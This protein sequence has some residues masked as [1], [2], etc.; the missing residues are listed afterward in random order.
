MH[1]RLRECTVLFT[2]VPFQSFMKGSFWKTQSFGLF[3]IWTDLKSMKGVVE[4]HRA[5][6]IVTSIFAGSCTQCLFRR[7]AKRHARSVSFAAYSSRDQLSIQEKRNAAV[8]RMTSYI[9][10]DSILFKRK[11]VPCRSG[12]HTARRRLLTASHARRLKRLNSAIAGRWECVA[13]TG[14]Q[15]WFIFRIWAIIGQPL[16]DFALIPGTRP[17]A[18]SD[19]QSVRP[20]TAA[21]YSETKARRRSFDHPD[22]LRCSTECMELLVE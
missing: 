6:R 9:L 13:L 12:S 7:M 16:N 18:L 11:T 20:F 17:F 22:D 2:S 19:R 8:N 15:P 5:S 4:S 14:Y 10:L 1:P 3:C 21:A